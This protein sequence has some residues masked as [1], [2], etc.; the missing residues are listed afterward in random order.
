MFT[1]T[2]DN[3]FKSLRSKGVG[4]TASATETISAEEEKAL[5]S[6]G[7]LNTKNPKGLVRA[8]FF[9]IGKTFC[10]HGGQEHRELKLSQLERLHDPDRYVY[11][12]YASKNKQGGTRQLRLDHKV[13]S[14][15]ISGRKTNHSL[16]VL[17]ATTKLGLTKNLLSTRA[18][19]NHQESQGMRYS[20]GHETTRP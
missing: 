16:R 15:G 12:E 9:V 17:G 14:A 5:W 11:Y 2:L 7:V 20:G 6:S 4:S 10:L 3:L 19:E 8:F 1:R 13:V 18:K